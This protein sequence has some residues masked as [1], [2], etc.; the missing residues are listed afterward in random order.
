MVST[1]DDRQEIAIE[2]PD[3]YSD[4]PDS[5]ITVISDTD[6]KIETDLKIETYLKTCDSY[7]HD[8]LVKGNYP[9]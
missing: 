1:Q 4:K 9:N 8:P 3:S 2:I 7:V 5:D 6:D